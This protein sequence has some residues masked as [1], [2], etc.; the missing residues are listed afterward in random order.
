MGMSVVEVEEMLARMNPKRRKEFRA[1][2]S[3]EMR[4]T[5]DKRASKDKPAVTVVDTPEKKRH[6]LLY[7]AMPVRWVFFALGWYFTMIGKGLLW[8]SIQLRTY[9]EGVRDDS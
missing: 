8:V 6:Y 9:I 1:K 4:E 2:L 5:I 7:V 3:V